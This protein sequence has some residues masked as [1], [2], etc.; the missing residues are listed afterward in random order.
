M[1]LRVHGEARAVRTPT[2]YIP[3]FED[4]ERLFKDVLGKNYTRDD[5]VAQFTIRVK[6]N[7]AKLDR[8]ERYHRENVEDPP[9]ELFQVLDTQRHR[10]EEA[11]REFGDL[12]SPECA[13]LADERKLQSTEELGAGLIMRSSGVA[14][15]LSE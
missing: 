8:V 15:S 11:R 7:L 4:L 5:Y 3:C 9:S 12:L 2:G 13:S 6:E 1:E 10:L 14:V